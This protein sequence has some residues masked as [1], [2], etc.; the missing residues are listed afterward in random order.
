MTDKYVPDTRVTLFGNEMDNPVIPASGT[1]GFGYEFSDWYDISI[2]GSIAL[3]GT[4]LEPR[5]GNPLPRI[6]ECPAGMINAIG[7]QNPGAVAV[8]DIELKKLAAVYPKKVIAN[9]GGHS[10]YEYTETARIL[11]G[12]DEVFAVELNVSCPNVKGGGMAFGIDPSVLEEL[13]A[14][15]KEV[16]SKPVMVKLS[17]N[18]TDITLLAKAAERGGA[19]GLSLI[20]TLVGMRIDLNSARPIISVK[21][22]GYSGPGVFPVAVN[23]VYNTRE[24]VNLPIVGMGGITDAEGVIEMMYAGADAV[25]VG[26][27]NLI[28]PFG[29]KK[30]IEALP[31]AM[32]RLG[33]DKLSDIT[34]RAHR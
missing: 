28:D 20:N 2:L 27:L 22:G 16:S 34:G 17:P 1:F 12:A 4:T 6:A 14:A 3:K 33:I 25:M 19:D 24:A 26:T 18:V 21:R 10:F 29:S 5:Y 15:V 8:R 7:L 11:S 31:K 23:A 30:I 9:V 13:T 32:E